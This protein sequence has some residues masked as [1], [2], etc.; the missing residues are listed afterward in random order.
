MRARCH[1]DRKQC[2]VVVKQWI[3]PWCA[4]I[5]QKAEIGETRGLLDADLTSIMV[6]WTDM[7]FCLSVHS[8][9]L[10]S[11]TSYIWYS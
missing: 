1:R 9:D 11:S 8:F 7:F 3:I 6:H 4:Q 10:L 2:Q 5:L